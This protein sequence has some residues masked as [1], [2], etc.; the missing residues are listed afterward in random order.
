MPCPVHAQQHMRQVIIGYQVVHSQF[1]KRVAQCSTKVCTL[2]LSLSS[3]LNQY[4]SI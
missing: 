1:I 3:H 2:W 4:D